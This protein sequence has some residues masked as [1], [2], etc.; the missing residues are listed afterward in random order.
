MQEIDLSSPVIADFVEHVRSGINRRIKKSVGRNDYVFESR[1]LKILSEDR[2]L[3]ADQCAEKYRERYGRFVSG[4]NV[5]DVLERAGIADS[6]ECE[7]IFT[8]AE[9]AAEAFV[10]ALNSRTGEDFE[11]YRKAQRGYEHNDFKS[12]I[13]CLML[14]TRYPELFAADTLENL[15]KLGKVSSK[16][17]RFDMQDFLRSACK[18]QAPEKKL[19][20]PDND[21]QGKIA[22]LEFKVKYLERQVEELENMLEQRE[23]ELKLLRSRV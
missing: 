1:V 15:E 12:K 16:F 6:S 19:R 18:I 2:T 23:N 11:N 9:N 10:T 7:K 4:E 5:S 17:L 8:W 20:A 13:F 3:S 22:E 21:S 14:Q